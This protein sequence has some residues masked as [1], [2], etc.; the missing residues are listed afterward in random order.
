MKTYFT[1]VFLFTIVITFLILYKEHPVLTVLGTVG[2]LALI[3]YIR[4]KIK[5]RRREK[6][7]ELYSSRRNYS[8][9]NSSFNT[10]SQM[11]NTYTSTS[12]TSQGVQYNNTFSYSTPSSKPKQPS[13]PDNALCCNCSSLDWAD[14]DNYGGYY[15]RAK[16]SFVH[17]SSRGCSRYS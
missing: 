5:K 10:T 4:I 6:E 2:I 13:I 9:N 12:N 3:I 1:V 15:C 16:G 8:R 14:K 7:L 17:P 11:N